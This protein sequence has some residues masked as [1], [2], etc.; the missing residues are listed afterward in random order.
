MARRTTTIATGVAGILALAGSRGPGLSST[1][2][3][4]VTRAA[5]QEPP[6]E[7]PPAEEAE[8]EDSGDA[9]N[10]QPAVPA[11]P[12]A[13]GSPAA[14]TE[15]EAPAESRP[16]LDPA[17]VR[18]RVRGFLVRWNRGHDLRDDEDIFAL[19]IVNSLLSLQLMSFV[20]TEF[21]VSLGEGDLELANFRT[22]NAITNLILSKAR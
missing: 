11:P 5:S 10:E 21:Q 16:A 18:S 17:Q 3:L 20:E 19:G 4:P 8:P 6:E 14:A 22:V 1:D 15:R 7:H 2:L 13:P 9:P 12:A